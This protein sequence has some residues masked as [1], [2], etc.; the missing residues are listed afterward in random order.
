MSEVNTPNTIPTHP[1]ASIPLVLPDVTYMLSPLTVAAMLS[2]TATAHDKAHKY[3]EER[4]ALLVKHDVNTP[5]NRKEVLDGLHVQLTS[6]MAEKRFLLSPEGT[7]LCVFWM[8]K[9]HHPNL[10]LEEV[11]SHVTL[12]YALEQARNQID[13]MTFPQRTDSP[14]PPSGDSVQNTS[15]TEVP[16]I[17]PTL[18]NGK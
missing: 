5:E 7:A 14:S 6:G 12:D 3:A 2:V 13:R 18:P 17:S 15:T 10:T 9:K 16:P 4:L 1:G 8:A 11:N